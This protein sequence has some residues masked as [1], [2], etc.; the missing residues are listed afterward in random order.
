MVVRRRRGNAAAAGAVP[1]VR[2]VVVAPLAHLHLAHAR[3]PRSCHCHHRHCSFDLEIHSISLSLC[4]CATQVFGLLPVILSFL[5]RTKDMP[6]EDQVELHIYGPV[7]LRSFVFACLE[8]P[9]PRAHSIDR[10][11]ESA[12]VDQNPSCREQATESKVNRGR[13]QVHELCPSL[14]SNGIVNPLDIY[15]TEDSHNNLLYWN[16]YVRR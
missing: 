15:P 7:G 6:L 1:D 12:N 5:N 9:H 8:V 11:V 16:V 3:R 4:V 2:S 13:V 10:S 14:P